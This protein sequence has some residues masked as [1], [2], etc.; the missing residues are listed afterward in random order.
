MISAAQLRAARAMLGI[1]QRRLAEMSDLSV[2]TIQRMEASEGDDSRQCRFADE[3]DRRSGC[4]RGRADRGRRAQPRRRSR[5]PSEVSATAVLLAAAAA[6]LGLA[7][8]GVALGRRAA[9]RWVV[10]AG[11]L[12]I[13]AVAAG[14]ALA[15][16]LG[17]IAGGRLHP[18][19]R[20]ALDR[21]A[22]P[23]RRAVGGVPGRG[24]PRRRRQPAS[25]PWVM[26]VTKP[27]PSGCCPSIRLSSPR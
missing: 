1:D 11:A 20:P 13:C 16:L 24:R 5:G 3:T 19:A 6:L 10:Y 18:A 14:L 4:R 8:A 22:V 26:A 27:S 23:P 9:G 7:P 2:P 15:T 17:F 12:I 21:S 25:M